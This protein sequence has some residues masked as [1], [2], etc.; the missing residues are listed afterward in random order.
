MPI[1]TELLTL[2]QCERILR[3]IFKLRNERPPR[4]LD[5]RGTRRAYAYEHENA[6]GLPKHARNIWAICHEAAHIIVPKV[7]LDP[8]A[9]HG[10]EFVHI[11]R[12]L[13]ADFGAKPAPV[14]EMELID[15]GIDF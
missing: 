5:G 4:L 2:E 1:T 14:S 15:M 12:H 3:H 8:R 11:Y 7:H 10:P 9:S 13:L 6:I